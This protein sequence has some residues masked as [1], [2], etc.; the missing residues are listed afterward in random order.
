MQE[1]LPSHTYAGLKDALWAMQI[2]SHHNTSTRKGW[3]L[4]EKY[5]LELHRK[6]Y[7]KQSA[8]GFKYILTNLLMSSELHL[9]AHLCGHVK[10]H[11]V[12]S[13]LTLTGFLR[14][15]KQY[16]DGCLESELI[17]SSSPAPSAFSVIPLIMWQKYNHFS[18]VILA[19][20]EISGLI[21]SRTHWFVF[22]EVHKCYI[23]KKSTFFL[24]A[25]F[26]V[27]LSHI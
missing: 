14:F 20:R 18:L 8:D 15:Y 17:Q 19:S 24:S 23:S 5:Y 6:S 25:F 12:T 11:W 26:N 4:Y 27:Q 2:P 13:K 16:S 21:W 7:G 1:G 3:W 9:S 10:C 22:L